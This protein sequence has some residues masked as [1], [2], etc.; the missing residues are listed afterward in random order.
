[1]NKMN[2]EIRQTEIYK[3]WFENLRDKKVRARIV[4]RI[5]RISSGNF[6][7]TKSVGKGVSEIRI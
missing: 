5:R 4:V 3:K 2:I 7:D 6:R 1:M